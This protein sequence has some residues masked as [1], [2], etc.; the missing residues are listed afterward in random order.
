L[1][2]GRRRHQYRPYGCPRVESRGLPASRRWN[3]A[4]CLDQGAPPSSSVTSDP[5]L[6]S[7]G[8]GWCPKSRS[9]HCDRYRAF[10][11]PP[12]R[13]GSAE[14]LL[15][16]PR[17]L[18]EHISRSRRLLRP[19][20]ATRR[21]PRD[22][23]AAARR[24]PCSGAGR[25]GAQSELHTRLENSG[26]LRVWAGQPDCAIEHVENSLRL[27]PRTRQRSPHPRA[28]RAVSLGS[29]PGD[30]RT[31]HNDRLSGGSPCAEFPG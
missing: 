30:G 17:G 6:R 16:I 7:R 9:F 8:R 1:L 19:F 25:I 4:V 28:T 24:R 5:I 27:S 31:R 15:A 26:I 29:A 18:A 14:A 22:H 3:W 11:Q 10:P 21:G 13:P 12:L 20:G 23:Q 2:L